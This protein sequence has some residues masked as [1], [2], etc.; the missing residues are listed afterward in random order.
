VPNLLFR[1]RSRALAV[2]EA[3]F[4]DFLEQTLRAERDARSARAREMFARVAGL[5]N[6]GRRSTAST[7]ALPPALPR[8]QIHELAG[9]SFIEPRRERRVSRSLRRRQDASG[10]RARYLATQHGHKVRFT[11]A[12]DL[13]MT[14]ETAQR[15]GRWKEA[16][17]RTVSVY[18]L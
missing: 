3:T 1:H 11:T 16:L 14:L 9:L 12:A 17:Q 8:P 7:S 10:D 4:A 15:Q 6:S 18:K 13:V 2:E 5:P